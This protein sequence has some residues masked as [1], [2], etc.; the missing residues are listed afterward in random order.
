MEKFE[1]KKSESTKPV[2]LEKNVS[3]VSFWENLKSRKNYIGKP[4]YDWLFF[5]SSPIWA[6]ALV[7]LLKHFQFEKI[8]VYFFVSKETLGNLVFSGLT[9]S[10]LF[11]VFFRSHLN[12]D[13]RSRFKYRFFVVPI[14][15]FVAINLSMWA[16]I[17]ASVVITWW[18]VYH[19]GL[20]TF[21]IARIY[22]KKIGNPA[23]LGRRLDIIMNHLTYMGP[24]L[25]GVNLMAHVEDFGD[26][27]RVNARFFTSI[28]SLVDANSASISAVVISFGIAFTI[29]YLYKYYS[30]YKQGYLIS[31][32]KV[33]LY[34]VT[35]MTSIACWGFSSFGAAFIIMNIFHA[36]QYFALVWWADGKNITEKLTPK[37]SPARKY[38]AIS[39][40]LLISFA[41]GSWTVVAVGDKLNLAIF[42]TVSILHF[43]Y[44]G[45]IWSVTKKDV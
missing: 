27:S 38:F 43:W 28:P 24:I 14:Y 30:Y 42:H 10:H 36:V 2:L 25:A 22:D 23:N 45:F 12:S 19:S 8:Q 26:F 16:M 3:I 7:L 5:L 34:S 29:F 33:V 17:I 13:I 35:F 32:Q 44:D 6:I 15:L 40:F 1:D 20:Q 11:A 21:G 39:A 41:Y 4:W 31:P 9:M 37:K 18:D